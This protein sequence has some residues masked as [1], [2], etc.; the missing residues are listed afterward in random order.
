MTAGV[1]LV[2]HIHPPRFRHILLTGSRGNT[3]VAV[4]G[5]LTGPHLG[6]SGKSVAILGH[7]KLE[8]TESNFAQLLPNCYS[9]LGRF[10]S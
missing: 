8:G 9:I 7:A 2:V 10:N 4:D 3:S 6:A 1:L 5:L